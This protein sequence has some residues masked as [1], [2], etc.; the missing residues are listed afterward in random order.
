ML[1]YIVGALGISAA[2]SYVFYLQSE[3]P[4]PYAAWLREM[5]SDDSE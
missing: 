3:S 2:A 4:L 1:G 5:Y